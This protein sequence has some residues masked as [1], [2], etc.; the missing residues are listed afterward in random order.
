[1]RETNE[2][3]DMNLLKQRSSNDVIGIDDNIRLGST[4]LR[5]TKI[6]ILIAF[7]LLGTNGKIE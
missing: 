7:S 6:L 4:Q 2:D 5:N 1:M 3:D